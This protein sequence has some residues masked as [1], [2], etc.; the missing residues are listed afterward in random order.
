MSFTSLD[1][2]CLV[3]KTQSHY[4]PWVSPIDVGGRRKIRCNLM[5][6]LECFGSIK[7]FNLDEFQKQYKGKHYYHIN[8]FNNFININND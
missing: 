3:G 4:V 7:N 1:E 8:N 2:F 5:K 6:L